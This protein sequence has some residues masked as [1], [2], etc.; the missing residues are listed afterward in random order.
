MVENFNS[1]IEKIRIRQGGFF[2]SKEIEI[3]LILQIQRLLQKRWQRS[4]P[5]F[6]SS[7]YEFNQLFHLTFDKG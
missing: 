5:L 6:K 3:N 1:L 7:S 2:P 4:H